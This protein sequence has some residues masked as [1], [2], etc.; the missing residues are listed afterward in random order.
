MTILPYWPLFRFPIT[1]SL[2]MFLISIIIINNIDPFN[3]TNWYFVAV[4]RSDEPIH[5]LD[6]WWT[7]QELFCLFSELNLTYLPMI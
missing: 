2:L 7:T 5:L 1:Q 4:E 6:E 3:Q